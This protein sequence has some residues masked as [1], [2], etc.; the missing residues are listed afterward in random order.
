M[1][2][3]IHQLIRSKRAEAY[4][5]FIEDDKVKVSFCSKD[6]KIE[7]ELE[8]FTMEADLYDVYRELSK[9]NVVEFNG[10]YFIELHHFETPIR[11]GWD[12]ID[13]IVEKEWQEIDQDEVCKVVLTLNK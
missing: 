10:E 2:N 11:S 3:K 9:N 1:K 6:R 7:K 13:Y 5:Y 8:G 12:D 4:E